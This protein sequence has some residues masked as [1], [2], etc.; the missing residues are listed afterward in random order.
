MGW[1]V[2]GEGLHVVFSRDIPTIVHEKVR[3]GLEEFLRANGLRLEE[4]DHLVA[5]PGGAK[6]LRAY[7]DALELP[8]NALDHPREVLRSYGNMSAFSC[9][10]VLDRFRCAREIANGDHAVVT[11]LGPGFSAEYVLLG[12]AS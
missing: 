12:G 11:A 1:E 5:H 9:L 10:F 3:P 6:V 7:A 8:A 4:L 2:D